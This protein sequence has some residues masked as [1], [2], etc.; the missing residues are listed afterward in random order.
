MNT[1]CPVITCFVLFMQC[2]HF[3]LRFLLARHK[4]AIEVYNEAEKMSSNDWVQK[5]SYVTH[6]IIY[7]TR[8]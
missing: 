8:K 7:Q 2:Y 5:I 4:A 6:K 3:I 1:Q